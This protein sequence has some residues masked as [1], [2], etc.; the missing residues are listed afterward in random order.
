MM[1]AI[2]GDIVGSRFEHYN[3]KRKEF[4]LFDNRCRFT[5][6]TVMTLAV[7][8]AVLECG[9]SMERLS[10]AA[11]RCMQEI[12]RHYPRCGWGRRF[13]DWIFSDDPQPYGS[14]GNGAA[15]RVSA[16][17]W[18]AKDIDACIAMSKAVTAV[19]H[20]HD[21]AYRGANAIAA[22]A[23][24]ALHGSTKE[25]IKTE[26]ENRFQ[27]DL[28]FTLDSI[29]DTYS[30]DVSCQGSVP[31]AIVSFLE[32]ADFEDAIRNA[33]SIG[34]DSD[35]IAACAGTI[36]EAYYGIPV[37]TRA[38]ARTYLDGRLDAILTDFEQA[39]PPKTA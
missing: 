14:W 39:F 36:A 17:A 35:T 4:R 9:D 38:C 6:D 25:E 2:I 12:G 19:S 16:V 7:A 31:Q 29:R 5:D 28:S 33:V 1:G 15:M 18:A 32:S 20:D 26:I 37:I 22:A 13:G 23:F 8:K 3:I 21:E 27:Y 10:D 24:L 34:G 30:F 11:V